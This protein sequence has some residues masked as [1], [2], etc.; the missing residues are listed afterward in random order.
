[1]TA[2]DPPSP[3]QWPADDEV[4]A[5]IEELEE[6]LASDDAGEIVDG[7][8]PPD[9]PF[10]EME[11]EI[12]PQW[13]RYPRVGLGMAK[14]RLRKL[15]GDMAFHGV[16]VPLYWLWF[17]WWAVLTL[18]RAAEMVAQ[19]LYHPDS[20]A[21]LVTARVQASEIKSMAQVEKH[22]DAR[23]NQLWFRVALF[24]VGV[25]AAWFFV[26]SRWLAASVPMKLLSFVLA[27][28]AV[29]WWSRP[30]AGEDGD[31]SILAKRTKSFK[32]EAITS[33][34]IATALDACGIEKLSRLIQLKGT[35]VIGFV[36]RI[37][38][39]SS[40]TATTT[41][42]ALPPGITPD[43]VINKRGEL[44]SAFG[45]P[46]ECLMLSTLRGKPNNWLEI[47]IL[48]EPMGETE[49]PVSPLLKKRSQSVF[50]P[51]QIGVDT[52]NRWIQMG[53]F[54]QSILIAGL[55]GHGK[56][57]AAR[58]LA[59]SVAPDPYV[60]F[61]IYDCKGLGDWK[62]FRKIAHSYASSMSM[63]DIGPK[64]LSDLKSINREMERRATI[65]EGLSD[66]ELADGKLTPDLVERLGLYPIVVIIDE[67]QSAFAKKP[68]TLADVTPVLSGVDIAEEF[69]NIVRKGRALG[70]IP[71]LITQKPSKEAIPTDIRDLFTIR[72]CGRITNSFMQRMI[73]GES[74]KGP[75]PMN[76]SKVDRGSW[77]MV[78]E[79]DEGVLVRVPNLSATDI[80]KV[81]DRAYSDRKRRGLLSGEAAG[82]EAEPEE[83]LDTTTV[84]VDLVNWWPADRKTIRTE[85]AAG[86]L[87]SE[88]RF[89]YPGWTSTQ[90]TLA[91]AR[92]G[93]KTDPKYIDDGSK[94][95]RR[96]VRLSDIEAALRREQRADG[97]IPALAEEPEPERGWDYVDAV[98]A[99]DDEGY[100]MGPEWEGDGPESDSEWASDE[101]DDA[102]GEAA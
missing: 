28:P 89:R 102:G 32:Y 96:G 53:L 87:S 21:D 27:V 16:R 37:Q 57:V 14:R 99:G 66:E 58:G 24:G 64:I 68:F 6:A 46:A 17:A 33:E 22:R 26:A 42:I 34:G 49:P 43:M 35:D 48:D 72:F 97:V 44:A 75:S 83:E 80:A 31:G 79:T 82:E 13:L 77:I 50:E 70:V 51:F 67:S 93:V 88:D 98:E 63:R 86:L 100:G 23:R 30:A 8:Q 38:R 59:G 19:F 85:E 15:G 7:D 101:A 73:I 2:I 4:D 69:D 40:D 41:T 74:Y 47:Y 11:R 91:L 94:Q 78:G 62:P 95:S 10:M 39:N 55:Q 18:G 52:R 65:F 84:L 12:L 92:F 1:M 36:D 29:G 61:Y 60:R 5:V 71:F 3:S 76:F 90:V 20:R 25:L 56:S 9:T 45:R 54:E 81:I